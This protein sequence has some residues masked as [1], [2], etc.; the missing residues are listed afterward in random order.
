MSTVILRAT[1]MV[2]VMLPFCAAAAPF[3]LDQAVDV[4]IKR[5]EL[6]RS[7]RAGVAS[8]LAISN[9]ASELP[10]PVLRLALEDVPVTGADRFR[11]ARDSMTTKRIG[12]AQ[13]WLSS[14]KRDARKAAAD[15]AVDRESITLQSAVAT[16]VYRR[17]SPSSMPSMPERRS[18]SRR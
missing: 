17:R 2:A 15:A 13:E 6:V 18:S 10:D 4:A 3:T 9:A 7:G 5:S 1:T 12:L 11:T 14:D 8:A 16:P